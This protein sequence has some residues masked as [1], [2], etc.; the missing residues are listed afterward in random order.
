MA[1]KLQ[2]ASSQEFV[3]VQDIRDGIVI[4]KDGSLRAI[5]MVSSLNFALKSTQEQEATIYQYQN[6]L[7]SLDFTVQY[8]IQS[9]KLNIDPYLDTLKDVERGQINELL[10]I[11]TREYIEFIKNF[12][13]TSNIVTKSFYVVIPYDPPIFETPKGAAQSLLGLFSAKKKEP[14]RIPDDKFE[15]YKT[16]LFQRVDSV[17]S[18]LTSS[19]VRVAPLNTDE[20]T[21]LYYSIFN[22][23]ENEKGGVPVIE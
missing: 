2:A 10:K 20:L 17:A 1:S 19:G 13:Q 6:F 14:K 18:G 4:L 5:L 7:N 3:P 8:F 22:P 15:E 9:R 16:Q 21:E 11:Q 12:V 23:G